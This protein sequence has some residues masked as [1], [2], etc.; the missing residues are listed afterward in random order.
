VNFLNRETDGKRLGLLHE[1]VPQTTLIAV[2]RNPARADAAD[3][4]EDV[5]KAARVLGKEISARSSRAVLLPTA[6]QGGLAQSAGSSARAEG[7]RRRPS[8]AVSAKGVWAYV[9]PRDALGVGG[10]DASMTYGAMKLAAA[11]AG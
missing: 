8:A 7:P 6:C 10:F 2:L 11:R 3:Q 5:Q 9:C 1:L 4:L